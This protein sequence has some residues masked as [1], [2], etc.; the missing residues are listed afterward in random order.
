MGSVSISNFTV[1][2]GL[3][4]VDFEESNVLE[5]ENVVSILDNFWNI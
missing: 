5:S 3:I 2:Q 1:D 4:I